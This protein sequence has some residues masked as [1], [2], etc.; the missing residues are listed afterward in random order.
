MSVDTPWVRLVERSPGIVFFN[1][2]LNFIFTLEVLMIFGSNKLCDYHCA[3]IYAK[4]LL[5]AF[6]NLYN[7]HSKFS[8]SNTCHNPLFLSANEWIGT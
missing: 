2:L 1:S 7:A 3:K 4:R 8:M 6:S 5:F